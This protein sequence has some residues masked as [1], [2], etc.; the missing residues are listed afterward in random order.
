MPWTWKRRRKPSSAHILTHCVTHFVTL[1][2]RLAIPPPPQT[3]PP[4][5]PPGS[6][7]RTFWGKRSRKHGGAYNTQ[8]SFPLTQFAASTPRKVYLFCYI[9]GPMSVNYHI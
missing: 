3:P 7:G 5:P 4:Y 1:W 9:T 2:P 8:P 6:R